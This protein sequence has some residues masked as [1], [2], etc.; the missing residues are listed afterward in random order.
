LCAAPAFAQV[1]NEIGLVRKLHDTGLYNLKTHEGQGAFVDA[2][3][4][5]L[6]G[7][8]DR[9]G[10]LRKKPGQTQV[11]GHG[12]DAV[13]YKLADGTAQ[14][15][16]FVGGAGGPNPTPTWNVDSNGPIYK[17][18]DWLDPF[19]HGLS[20]KPP[21]PPPAPSYPPYPFPEAAV[22]GAGIAL[23]LDFGEAGQPPN[24]QMFRFAFRV[25][26]SWLTK[27]V[28]DLPASV[29]K[30]RKEWRQLLGLPPLQ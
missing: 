2:V 15:I 1:P 12:E 27:E 7:R 6:H 19:D 29:A 11:H 8:D 16:D 28:P 25:A 26:Y 9:F 18:S 22:D 3:V 4:A 13:L 24:Q 30:H 14:A 10:H 20:S 21:P 23:F 5:T 17:H